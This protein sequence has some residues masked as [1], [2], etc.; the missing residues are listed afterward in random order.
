MANPILNKVK[1]KP[2]VEQPPTNNGTPAPTAPTGKDST[3]A[4][5]GG[6]KTNHSEETMD[7]D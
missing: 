4:P 6:E 3:T 2:K 5:S 7:V 1:P